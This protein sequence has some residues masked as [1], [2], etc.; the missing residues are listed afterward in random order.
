MNKCFLNKSKCFR[1][2]NDE[3]YSLPILNDTNNIIALESN[4][5]D[6]TILNNIIKPHKEIQIVNF[7]T[8]ILIKNS[9]LSYKI[10]YKTDELVF[11][12]IEFLTN[13][14][15]WDI[16]NI[17]IEYDKINKFKLTQFIKKKNSNAKFYLIENKNKTE[18]FLNDTILSFFAI[19][20]K[21]YQILIKDGVYKQK[22][23]L[24][25]NTIES[26]NNEN[27]EIKSNYNKG[28]LYL[29]VIKNRPISEDMGIVLSGDI[30][31]STIIK[32]GEKSIGI[33]KNISI[34]SFQNLKLAINGVSYNHLVYNP[35]HFPSEITK[36]KKGI[37]FNK[38]CN[39]NMILKIGDS[40]VSV[41]SGTKEIEKSW[42]GIK[43]ISLIFNGYT[44]CESTLNNDYDLPKLYI[45]SNPIRLKLSNKSL[46]DVYI[47][48]QR[49]DK[50]IL[51]PS[52]N[53]ETELKL[54]KGIITLKIEYVENCI[55]EKML[56]RFVN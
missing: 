39:E 38:T 41:L 24:T 19:K 36:T 18:I 9:K 12:D 14:D 10:F 35:D 53:T 7:T 32:S 2:K 55:C 51:I 21:K 27:F 16:D 44:I 3:M 48:L 22:I 47:K 45:L 6:I 46:Q 31:K 30:N 29:Y 52:G 40:D 11:M 28:K 1:L 54:P 26:I 43:K 50:K 8:N 25:G 42:I 20:N 5:K 34:K 37:R 17:D 13:H 15:R 4:S 33:E 56:Y 23:N 49:F